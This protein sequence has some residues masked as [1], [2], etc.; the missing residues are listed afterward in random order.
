MVFLV[1]VFGASIAGAEAPA[2]KKIVIIHTNDTH[3]RVSEST[4]DGM[5]FAKIATF[6]KQY[7]AQNPNTLVLDAGDTFHGQTIATLVQGES[8]VKI[9]NSIGYDAMT[10]GNHDFNYGQ[11][12]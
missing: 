9:M 12:R 2:E 3:S 11:N 10:P 7:K 8:I 5:G 4:N 1:S 6:V